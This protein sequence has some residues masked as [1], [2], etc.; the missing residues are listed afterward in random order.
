[1]DKLLNDI[2][3]I[4]KDIIHEILNDEYKLN[5]FIN[6]LKNNLKKKNKKIFLRN[7]KS[8]LLENKIT[9]LDIRI[10][11]TN[12]K[13]LEKFLQKLERRRSSTIYNIFSNQID[14]LLYDMW[15]PRVNLTTFYS[16]GII[17]D[18]FEF[19]IQLLLSELSKL[20]EPQK[21]KIIQI[22]YDNMGIE[23]PERRYINAE[24]T[25]S[26]A[27]NSISG[28]NITY[29]YPSYIT[30]TSNDSK[31]RENIYNHSN[32][33]S[34]SYNTETKEDITQYLEIFKDTL[35]NCKEKVL[36]LKNC[37]NDNA[38]IE[39]CNAL[40]KEI[41][42]Q[43]K[44]AEASLSQDIKTALNNLNNIV[45]ETNKLYSEA[46][47]IKEKINSINQKCMD[48]LKEIKELSKDF[49]Y[50]IKND[51]H[52]ECDDI[53]KRLNNGI[54]NKYELNKI[55]DEINNLYRNAYNKKHNKSSLAYIMD[56]EEDDIDLIENI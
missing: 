29:S 14:L 12:I 25:S 52:K 27:D 6:R 22:F 18:E 53:E 1:M 4:Y 42:K 9:N 40:E 15:F 19:K 41:E 7:F 11:Y 48:K 20:P 35:N 50:M 34:T 38:L 46:S 43:L 55:I 8:I 56:V 3:N 30:V 10:M 21:E 17:I 45:D 2:L 49:E 36:S 28:N 13:V 51:Y 26:V 32:I 39:E 44:N 33:I 23:L 37:L 47:N 54:D 16:S 24:N 31:S 5:Q